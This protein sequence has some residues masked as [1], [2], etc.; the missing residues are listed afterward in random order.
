MKNVNL[1]LLIMIFF[2]FLKLM[3]CFNLKAIDPDLIESTSN[4]I[5]MENE[6]IG[7]LNQMKK[8]KEEERKEKQ[9]RWEIRKEEIEKGQKGRN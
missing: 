8:R 3:V 6:L 5:E 2:S 1:S 9:G 4:E 7:F